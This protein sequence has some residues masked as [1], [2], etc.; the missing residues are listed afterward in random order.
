[1]QVVQDPDGRR[2]TLASDVDLADS[3]R[4]Q[5]VGL[6]G[7]SSLPE[8]YALVFRFD[9]ASRRVV[10]ML[11]VRVALDVVWLRDDEVIKV[12]R[13]SPWTGLGY[14]KADAMIELPAGAAEDVEPGDTVVVEE[15]EA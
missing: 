11:F 10:H 8:E 4:A 6:M 15:D 9:D 3:F 2:R 5:T 7:R 14:A 12:Q 13:L 1:M